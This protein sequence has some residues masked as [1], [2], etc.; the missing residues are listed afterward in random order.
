VAPSLD[1]K[2]TV[3]RIKKEKAL[4]FPMLAGAKPSAKSWDVQL[5]P[6]IFLVGRDGKLLWKGAEKNEA[7]H[8]ALQA[9][10]EAK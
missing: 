8:K 9:A 5:F 7:F 3:E 6:G 2:E 1:A 10:L 4:T